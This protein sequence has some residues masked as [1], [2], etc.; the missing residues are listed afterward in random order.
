MNSKYSNE[1]LLKLENIE[2]WAFIS[3]LDSAFDQA[4]EEDGVRVAL[5]AAYLS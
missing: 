1:D 3:E 5:K 4:N 2:R